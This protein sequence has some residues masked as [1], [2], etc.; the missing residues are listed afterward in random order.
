MTMTLPPPKALK[1]V[2]DGLLGKD[3]DLAPASTTLTS[4]DAVGGVV[5]KYVDDEGRP[6]AVLGWDLPA[7]AHAGAAFALIPARMA[8][9]IVDERWLP[10][11]IVESV[12]EL[13]NVLASALHVN[14]NPHT[15]LAQT[16]H[17][18]AAAPDDLAKA[19]YSHYERMDFDVD[20][21]GYGGG[22]LSVVVLG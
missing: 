9:E 15:K 3:V 12:Y 14:G 13:S 18:A 21:P 5:A 20:V 19:L 11:D 4:V 16:Y 8:E 6:R 7:A 17:P 10:E 1:D 2:I 22:R